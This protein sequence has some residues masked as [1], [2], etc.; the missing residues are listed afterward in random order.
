MNMSQT[1][2]FN[3]CVWSSFDL[4]YS[5]II[6]AS[7]VYSRGLHILAASNQI[8]GIYTHGSYHIHG[9]GDLESPHRGGIKLHSN[10]D[11]ALSRSFWWFRNKRDN[12]EIAQSYSL[13]I[14][15]QTFVLSL[16]DPG[17]PRSVPIKH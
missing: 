15:R 6:H 2:G 16:Y 4:D 14:L 8:H 12:P 1:S 5:N 10:V 9:V 13:H 11:A 17:N 3:L 7:L